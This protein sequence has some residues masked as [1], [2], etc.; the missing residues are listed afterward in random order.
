MI[1]LMIILIAVTLA[2][3]IFTYFNRRNKEEE[4]E[5]N[6]NENPECCGAHEVCDRDSLQ[7]ISPDIEY[8]DD[9]ELDSLAGISPDDFTDKQ[10][11]A[12]ENVFYSMQ[13]NDVSAWLKSLKLRNIQLPET[14]QEEALLIVRERRGLAV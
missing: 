9:E 1:P 5:V 11:E 6:L 3:A 2:L 13:E 14:I 4:V 8:F 10:V 7:I 12:I